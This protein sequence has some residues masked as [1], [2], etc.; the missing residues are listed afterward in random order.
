MFFL[1]T[2]ARTKNDS[3]WHLASNRIGTVD[4][5]VKINKP[6]FRDDTIH[7]AIG[8]PIMD[9]GTTSITAVADAIALSPRD[10]INKL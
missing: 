3:G 7:F 2:K 9:C 5:L 1:R 6:P 4:R 8:F 10:K